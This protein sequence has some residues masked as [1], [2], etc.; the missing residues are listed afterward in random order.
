MARR[1]VLLQSSTL[2]SFAALSLARPIE[3]IGHGYETDVFHSRDGNLAL[4]LKLRAGS[5]RAMLARA[6][7]LR[8][9]AERF[10]AYLGP[11]HSLPSL[12]LLVAAPAGQSQIL[13]IQPFLTDAHTLDTV[14][15]A[16]LGREQ[17]AEVARQLTAIVAGAIACY[18]ATGSMPDLYGLGPHDAAQA[19]RWDPRWVLRSARQM[20]LGR[21][22][23]TAHNLMLTADG[24][25]VL[26][27]YDPICHGWLTCRLSYAARALLLRR[28]RGHIAAL[29]A[30]P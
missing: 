1:P 15:V 26:V 30:E 21:P 22:L 6:R 19:R 27:D 10:A 14:D 20:L 11:K 9:V 5:P 12:Y 29:T 17:R 3:Q 13:A 24:R 28:D 25:V 4:K 23:I 16:G 18:K 2:D 8:A 7:R